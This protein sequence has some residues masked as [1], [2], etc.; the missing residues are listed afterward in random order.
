M[1]PTTAELR[2]DDFRP[3]T[4]SDSLDATIPTCPG[5]GRTRYSL[6]RPRPHGR[7]LRPRLLGRPISL[8]LYDHPHTVFIHGP[9]LS[10]LHRPVHR[11]PGRPRLRRARRGQAGQPLG[12]DRRQPTAGHRHQRALS[13]APRR[14]RRRRP[15]PAAQRRADLPTAGHPAQ[16]PLVT[17]PG[18]SLSR[19]PRGWRSPCRVGS[20]SGRPVTLAMP[21]TAAVAAGLLRWRQWDARR[22]AHRRGASGDEPGTACPGETSLA[23]LGRY[24]IPPAR[25]TPEPPPSLR[26]PHRRAE[27]SRAPPTPPPQETSMTTTTTDWRDDDDRDEAPAPPCGRTH[28]RRGHW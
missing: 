17:A 16:A 18:S 4:L 15:P 11:T 24:A 27:A 8:D 12:P 9:D 7:D 10:G 1:T 19:G 20:R 6:G 21:A 23:A 2:P 26:D 25:A 3:Y 5:A 14:P 13:R 22:S 28:R